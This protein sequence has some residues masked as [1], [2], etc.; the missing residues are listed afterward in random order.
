MLNS[1]FRRALSKRNLGKL[2]LCSSL[3]EEKVAKAY[4]H[5]AKLTTDKIIRGLLEYIAHDSFKHASCFKSIAEVLFQEVDASSE[6]CIEAWGNSWLAVVKD[7]ERILETQ[8]I[9][10]IDLRSI[11]DA[12]YSIEGFVAEEYLTVLHVKL[13]EL[14]SRDEEVHLDDFKAVL[15]WIVEDEERHK[16]ILEIIRGMLFKRQ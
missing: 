7:A 1:S 9:G 2:F 14:M 4:E 16:K 11:I 12:L 5:V 3:L 8:K 10:L 15:D 13:I 6:D